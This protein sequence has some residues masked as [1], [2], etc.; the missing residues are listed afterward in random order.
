[1]FAT[2]PASIEYIR[3]ALARSLT[4]PYLMK[5][6]TWTLISRNDQHLIGAREQRGR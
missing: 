4:S 1:M 5:H 6:L 3:A 2:I